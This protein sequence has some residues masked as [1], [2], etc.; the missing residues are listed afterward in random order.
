MT[1]TTLFTT[2]L[3]LDLVNGGKYMERITVALVKFQGMVK[4]G[5]SMV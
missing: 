3:N 2:V 4:A 5:R 1:T